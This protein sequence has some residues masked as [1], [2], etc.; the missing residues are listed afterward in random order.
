MLEMWC[1][2][3]FCTLALEFPSFQIIGPQTK[4]KALNTNIG[5]IGA[6]IFTIGL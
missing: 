6:L 1:T 2:C 4:L 3:I 5:A